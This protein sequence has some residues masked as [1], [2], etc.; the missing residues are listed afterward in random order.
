MIESVAVFGVDSP[1]YRRFD[2][3]P[4]NRGKRLQVISKR[5]KLLAFPL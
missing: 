2:L 5:N 3:T 4:L 1:D